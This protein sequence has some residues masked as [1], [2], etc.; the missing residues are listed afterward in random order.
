MY[1]KHLDAFM[2]VVE[3]GS[4]S[5]A[6]EAA[7]ISRTALIQQINLLEEHVGLE[8]FLRS[9][10]GIKLTP[11]GE[12]F[13][14]RARA[15][16][17]LSASTIAECRALENVR[18]IRIGTLPN[19]PLTILAPIC[20]EYH[21]LFPQTEIIFVE[22]N[23]QE[24]LASFQNNEFDISADYMSRLV[25]PDEDICFT[26][27]AT[28]SFDAAVSPESEL[29]SKDKLTLDDLVG[30][31]V[32]LLAAN[33]ALAEDSMRKLIT[34][35]GKHIQ[36]TDIYGYSRS[37]PITCLLED[38]VF[39]HYHINGSEYAPLVSLPLDVGKE[40]PVR[41]GLCY[42]RGAGREVRSFVLFA[43]EYCGADID[44]FR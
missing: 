5:K 42:K 8:L 31:K 12:L 14:E 22:R 28:D 19:L 34:S 24:Y 26:P 21:R 27:L 39:I 30:R 11:T 43:S 29:A 16:M 15:I 38:A 33:L 6:A 17:S 1:N 23:A 7:H 32:Y 13:R 41:L 3:N 40:C 25:L 37:L 10:K 9:S 20:A 36:I 18:Q 35:S 4:F 44:R 2:S